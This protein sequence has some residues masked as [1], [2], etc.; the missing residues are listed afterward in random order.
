MH[1]T[2]SV[3][4]SHKRKIYRNK[5]FTQSKIFQPLGRIGLG[6]TF[7]SES[8]AVAA[9]VES[10]RRDVANK[11]DEKEA[12]L[13]VFWLIFQ[14]SFLAISDALTSSR[15]LAFFLATVYLMQ[16][17]ICF[18]PFRFALPVLC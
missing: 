11:N 7:A 1:R 3:H 5:C 16:A 8:M 18:I 4:V 13:S 9:I 17:W 15:M 2:C 6:L 10:M 14:Y 12:L